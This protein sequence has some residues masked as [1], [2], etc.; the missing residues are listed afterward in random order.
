MLRMQP[1]QLLNSSLVALLRVRP[2]LYFYD[3]KS[4]AA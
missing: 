3:V 4:L 2:S 1:S